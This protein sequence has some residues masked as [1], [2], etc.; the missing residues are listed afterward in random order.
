MKQELDDQ[1][2]RE[3]PNLYRQR[4]SDMRE[5]AMCW[6]FE[7]NSGWFQLLY[8]LSKNLEQEILKL[9]EKVQEHYCASQVKEKYG[10][11]RFYTHGETDEMSFWIR[12]A[13]NKSNITCEICGELGSNKEINGWYQTLCQKHYFKRIASDIM[14]CCKNNLQI[15]EKISEYYNEGKPYQTLE[16]KKDDDIQEVIIE[17]LLDLLK[18]PRKITIKVKLEKLYWHLK[19]NWHPR[20]WCVDKFKTLFKYYKW[21][22]NRYLSKWK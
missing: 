12:E 7:C 4:N 18:P 13:E 9:P 3:F 19:W 20:Y 6:G 5:T 21:K 8:D 22:T 10:T 2:C 17:E 14:A 11:L 16:Y 15:V 1:L